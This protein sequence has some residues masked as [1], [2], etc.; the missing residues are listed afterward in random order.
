MQLPHTA[1]HPPAH[2]HPGLAWAINL[3]LA[4]AVG[5]GLVGLLAVFWGR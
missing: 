5:G 2:G 4:L 1:R 3:A